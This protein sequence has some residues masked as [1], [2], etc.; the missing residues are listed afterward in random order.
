MKTRNLAAAAMGLCLAV[1]ASPAHS[2]LAETAATPPQTEKIPVTDSY[3][4]VSVVDEYRWLEDGR[5]PKVKAWVAAQNAYSQAYLSKLPQRDSIVRFLKAARQKEQVRYGDLQYAGGLLF[6][7]K[8]DP[9]KSASS[10]VVFRSPE[11][12]ASERTVVDLN[13][14]VKG[15]LFQASWYKPSPDGTMVGMALGTGGSEDAALYVFD[16]ATGKQIGD[17]VPRVQFATA[18]GD[19]AWT[20]DDKGFYY[21][22]Y[23]QGNERPAEDANFYQQVYYH[24]LGSSSA[25]DRYVLGKEFPRIG[26][27]ALETAHDGKHILVTVEDGDGGKYEHFLVAPDGTVNQI[28]HFD[29]K[30]VDIQFGADDSLWLLSHSKSDRGELDHLAAGSV[31]LSDAVRVIPPMRGSI[32]GIG[33]VGEMRHFLAA[34]HN[35]YVTVIDGG[36]E[37]ILQFDLRGKSEGKVP[38]P[39][40]ASVSTLVPLTGDAFL[41]N[42]GTY[43]QPP[44]W[45]R[46]NGAG[47]PLALPFKTDTGISLADI[48]VRREF[49]TSKDGTKVPMTVLMRKGTRLDGA[50]PTFLTGYGGYG[51][52]TTPYFLG[53]FGRLWFDHGGVYVE[54]NIRGGAEYGESWHTAGNLLNKQNVFDDFAACA[55][56]L[57]DARY[58]SSQ[59]LAIEGGSNGGLL[60]GAEL[61]QH[62]Q[63]FRVVLSEVGIY[64]MLRVELDPNGSFN[65]TEFG[66]V[67]D[68]ALFKALYAYSPYHHVKAGTKYPAVLFVTGDNDHRVNPA[69]S[70]KMIAELQAATT[71]GLPVLLRTNANAG[72]GVSTDKDE[73]LEERADIYSFLFAQL[74]IA[75]N[76]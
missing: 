32:E 6:A 76:H 29:D 67:K 2:A 12:Q 44:Q 30:V 53:A 24:A 60:M 50:N 66:T 40:V 9:Q 64:D 22:R 68:P 26:E 71:S 36:P 19:M 52:S 20:G 45:F 55:Q 3:H 73:A 56:H 41:Y 43:T 49:A 31:K 28:T 59:H 11:D 21:T 62:P 47:A 63:M 13:T 35:L 48:E 27:T 4:G 14:L 18:G 8:R 10:L 37:E 34:D 15:Q 65:V 57:I 16:V 39:N 38:L 58:T 61:T 70:R 54:A 5:D 69:H 74:G 33:S 51:I 46:Y 7:L 42:A 25:Q 1:C 72:H 17:P 23:P 75:M